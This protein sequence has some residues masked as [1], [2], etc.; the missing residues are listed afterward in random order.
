MTQPRS[1][2]SS[3]RR[4]DGQPAEGSESLQLPLRS[5][6]PVSGWP[7]AAL[8]RQPTTAAGAPAH[9]IV[10]RGASYQRV[11]PVTE[12]EVRTPRR[13]H[14][15]SRQPASIP[16]CL[17]GPAD[18]PAASADRRR[19]RLGGRGHPN[20][21]QRAD[22]R[23]R[24][25]RVPEWPGLAGHPLVRQAAGGASLAAAAGGAH[26]GIAGAGRDGNVGPCHARA[27]VV[28]PACP[29]CARSIGP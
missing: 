4:M 9:N 7:P 12:Q 17:P 29:P 24:S 27:T 8:G 15:R 11:R 3:T 26:G 5:S 1:T 21:C 23:G 19:R 25:H 28:S 16:G 14:P 13:A 18:H 2:W 10:A 6:R 22:L 20:R